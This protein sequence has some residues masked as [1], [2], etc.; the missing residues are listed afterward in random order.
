MQGYLCTHLITF[1]RRLVGWRNTEVHVTLGSAGVVFLIG[2][3]VAP[4]GG[5]H[6]V[7]G[8]VRRGCAEE[9][10]VVRNL[11]RTQKLYVLTN[12]YNTSAHT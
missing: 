3:G 10:C 5:L 11:L 7:A 12:M 9:K 4:V 6:L 2:R 1:W 8:V